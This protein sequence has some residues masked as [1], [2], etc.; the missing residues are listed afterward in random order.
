MV[1]AAV[2]EPTWTTEP[3]RDEEGTRICA[4]DGC[5][6][7]HCGH[8][9][10]DLHLKRWRTTGDPLRASRFATQAEKDAFIAGEIESRRKRYAATR[11]K[12]RMERERRDLL[13]VRSVNRIRPAASELI[14]ALDAMPEAERAAVADVFASVLLGQPVEDVLHPNDST[15][16]TDATEE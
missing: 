7:K 16:T 11:E 12:R 10:C 13:R 3:I 9:L 6:R 2:S 15:H 4:L 8:G 14:R 5:S 1:S